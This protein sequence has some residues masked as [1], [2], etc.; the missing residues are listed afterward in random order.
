MVFR[1]YLEYFGIISLQN[2][3]D[4]DSSRKKI[5]REREK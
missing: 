1:V 3:D 5:E 2:N 4:L